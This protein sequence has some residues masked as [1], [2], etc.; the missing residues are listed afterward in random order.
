[1]DL[2]LAEWIYDPCAGEIC[3]NNTCEQE[4]GGDLCGCPELPMTETGENTLER[5]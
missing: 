5:D 1:M 4:N 2:Y 3:S